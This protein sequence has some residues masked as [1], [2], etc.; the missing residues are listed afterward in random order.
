[1]TR[2]RQP[3]S[4]GFFLSMLFAS[5]LGIFCGCGKPTTEKSASA[6]KSE[7]AGKKTS[8]S[9]NSKSP[10]KKRAV[11]ETADETVQAVINSFLRK[12][13][14]EIWALLPASY[15]KDVNSLVHD[16]AM[17]M[18]R[19]LWHH[20]FKTIQRAVA[21]CKKR[22]QEALQ[23]PS[24]KQVKG[25]ETGSLSKNYD[26]TIALLEILVNSDIANLD[27]MK[28]MDVGKFLGSTGEGFLNKTAALSRLLPQDVFQQELDQL[29]NM[30]A[31]LL[32]SEKDTAVVRLSFRDSPDVFR[33]VPF[34]K[35]EGKW[36][37]ESWAKGWKAGVTEIQNDLRKKLAPELL[38]ERKKVAIQYLTVFDQSL[39]ELE[40]AKT[41]GE[42][43]AKFAQSPL[44]QVLVLLFREPT[45]AISGSPVLP[46]S[47]KDKNPTGKTF[48][49]LVIV[50]EKLPEKTAQK[51]ADLLFDLDVNYDVGDFSYEKGYTQ[52]SVSE[53]S[54]FERFRKQIKF[55]DV[56]SA[57]PAQKRIVLRLK[58]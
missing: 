51:I 47:V 33:E 43:Q 4:N 12:K 27:A 7:S 6:T 22:R 14:E 8:E 30:R 15:Q 40:A 17:G 21:V 54:D 25:M 36:L 39:A 31:S 5:M 37:P 18:D 45:N 57:N 46:K 58:K 49:V 41:A 26:S 16:F 52:F 9:P 53:I 11:P 10:T 2:K 48:T 38:A 34:V 23:S 56:V 28:S 29:G 32:S 24:W 19:E 44:L 13:P 20:T 35:V 1:M 3:V 55:A 50:Q 42:F